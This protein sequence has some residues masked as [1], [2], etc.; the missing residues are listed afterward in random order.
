MGVTADPRIIIHPL[1]L[2][3]YERMVDAGILTE[4]DKV[5]LIN[6]VICEMTPQGDGHSYLIQWLNMRLVRGLP[7]GGPELR[8]QLP[9]R[10]PPRSMPEPDFTIVE[11]G[12]RRHPSTALLVIEIANTSRRFD[13][14]TKAELY[15][16]Q[17]LPEYW[18]I[19]I[20]AR[21]VHVHREPFP[22]G[23]G[24]V[25][26]VSSGTLKA[27]FAGA[28]AVDLDAMFATLD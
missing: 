17:G 2:A 24:S 4:D 27:T 6:G 12:Q 13:L 16:A 22:D 9:M 5:E 3:D 23:Y 19:D 10:L 28:P 18:V 15:A 26:R 7:E 20:R 8:P 1:K 21:T 14:G 25:V 11:P